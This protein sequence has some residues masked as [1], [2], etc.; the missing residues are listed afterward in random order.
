V[1]HTEANGA[2]NPEDALKLPTLLYKA[3]TAQHNVNLVVSQDELPENSIWKQ[4][5]AN[6]DSPQDEEFWPQQK[7]VVYG[8]LPDQAE[9]LK[10]ECPEGIRLN[11][12]KSLKALARKTDHETICVLMTR[13]TRHLSPDI[14]ARFKEVV[15]AN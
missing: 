5:S 1:Q 3:D 9:E 8:L 4:K 2:L 10:A 7:V 6:L 15:Y 13:F 11:C 12:V 14:K